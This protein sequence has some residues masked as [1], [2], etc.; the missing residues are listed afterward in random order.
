MDNEQIL[1]EPLLTEKTNLLREGE[2]KKFAFKVS[3]RANKAMIMKAVKELF[4]VNPV[5]CRVVN[6]NGKKKVVGSKSGHRKG[7]GTT[8]A[9]KK[10]YVTLSKGETIEKFEGV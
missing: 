6:V 8:S 3:P 9:W 1:I 10:A 4:S 2:S 7:Y 5:S